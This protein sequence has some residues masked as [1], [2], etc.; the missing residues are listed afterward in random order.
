MR[1]KEGF[2]DVDKMLQDIGVDNTDINSIMN[3]EKISIITY[4][5]WKIILSFIYENDTYFYK[6]SGMSIP[7]NELIAEELAK[8]FGINYVSYDLAVLGQYKGVLSKNFIKDNE[9]YITGEEILNAFFIDNKDIEVHNNLGDIWDALEYRYQNYPNRK[10]L[11]KSL[12]DDIINIYIY[13]IITCQSD[14]HSQNWGLIENG[15]E[16]YIQPIFDNE[17][18]LST[19]GRQAFVNLT[20]DEK[21]NSN[22]LF[23]LIKFMKTS[24]ISYTD[25]IKEKLWII[26]DENLKSVFKKIDDK[27]GYP[28]SDKFKQYYLKEYQS[29]RRRLEKVLNNNLERDDKYERKNR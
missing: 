21:E 28:M 9:K 4:N 29:H 23:N 11:I 5:H 6:Y 27:T 3:N 15:N 19:N 1:R 12:M 20:I 25:L 24:S 13:D 7:Y 17:R 16:V 10:E 14:R 2:I 18:I 26:S 22:L 8:D